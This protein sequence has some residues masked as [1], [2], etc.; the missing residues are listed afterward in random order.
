MWYLDV[1]IIN[2]WGFYGMDGLL[3]L[4]QSIFSLP[5]PFQ[6]IYAN[7]FSYCMLSFDTSTMNVSAFFFGSLEGLI[8]NNNLFYTPIIQND[9]FPQYYV[10]HNW[11]QHQRHH[12]EH[13][14]QRHLRHKRRQWI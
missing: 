3:G 7:I 4:G 6:E 14:K 5:S 11:N 2:P 10:G 9:F 12:I 1:G 13:P 8:I